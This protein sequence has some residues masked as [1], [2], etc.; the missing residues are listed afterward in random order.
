MIV[1]RVL[2][3]LPSPHLQVTQYPP[4][5][6]RANGPVNC[7]GANTQFSTLHGAWL[8]FRLWWGLGCV[9]ARVRR[10]PHRFSPAFRCFWFIKV[11]KF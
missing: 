2:A 5:N 10:P 1:R 4:T 7:N 8:A 3:S 9:T 11:H 6:C